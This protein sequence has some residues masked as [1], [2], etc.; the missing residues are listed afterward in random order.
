MTTSEFIVNVFDEGNEGR[1]L[2]GTYR[3]YREGEYDSYELETSWEH[4]ISK[5]RRIH[6][7]DV[8]DL[9]DVLD[10]MRNYGWTVDVVTTVEVAY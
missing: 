8:W 10:N 5:A 1:E 7:D 3:V 9:V 4:S 6:K 2:R